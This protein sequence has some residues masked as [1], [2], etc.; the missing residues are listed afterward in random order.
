MPKKK[1]WKAKLT[2]GFQ[3]MM[4]DLDVYKAIEGP[5]VTVSPRPRTPFCD[6]CSD[7]TGLDRSA[8]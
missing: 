2:D 1:F 8:G 6:G 7:W 5:R 4:I 3:P